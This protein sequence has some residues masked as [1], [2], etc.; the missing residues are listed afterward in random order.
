MKD[1][2]DFI[3]STLTPLIIR[4]PSCFR[5]AAGF[6]VI[7][8]VFVLAVAGGR[9]L[10]FLRHKDE[11]SGAGG[12]EEEDRAGMSVAGAAPGEAGIGPRKGSIGYDKN[13]ADAAAEALGASAMGSYQAPSAG[14]ASGN[15]GVAQIRDRSRTA[16][17]PNSGST[18]ATAGSDDPMA[19]N[20]ALGSITSAGIIV[21]SSSPGMM[22]GI[23]KARRAA[24]AAAVAR[25]TKASRSLADDG[26]G[27]LG[28]DDMDEDDDPF[29]SMDASAGATAVSGGGAGGTGS[30]DDDGDL[31]SGT[32]ELSNLSKFYG[33]S[34]GRAGAGASSGGTPGRSG[35][36]SLSFVEDLT[37]AKPSKWT[38]TFLATQNDRGPL[39]APFQ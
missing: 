15:G 10:R 26:F 25:D 24:V 39:Y 18:G 3:L 5:C 22:S 23:A 19:V 20:S 34:P 30:D 1:K 4:L 37:P 31:G 8:I 11:G 36:R 16:F 12:A 17:I 21:A 28:G 29:S 2:L 33:S 7:Y 9:W 27:G 32:A 13:I 35:G 14:D 6:I 38:R